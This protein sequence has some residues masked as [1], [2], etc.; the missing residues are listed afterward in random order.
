MKSLRVLSLFVLVVGGAAISL[1]T[2]GIAFSFLFTLFV[3]LTIS[4]MVFGYSSLC[5]PLPLIVGSALLLFHRHRELG[6]RLAVAGS[7]VRSC[8]GLP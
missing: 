7:V 8:S 5:G 6:A 2:M 3:P 4:D 1:L